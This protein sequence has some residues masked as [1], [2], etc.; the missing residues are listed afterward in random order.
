MKK[1]TLLLSCIKAIFLQPSIAATL[2]E[3]LKRGRTGGLIGIKVALLQIREGKQLTSNKI[4][5]H[6][7][8]ERLKTELKPMILQQ[9]KSMKHKPLIT[10]LIPTYNTPPHFLIKT[11]ESVQNQWYD[12]WELCICDDA[13]KNIKTLTI[14]KNKSKED[15]R[16][17][18]NF[19]SHNRNI[20][21]ATNI[22]L[23]MAQGQYV[24]LLDHDDL[25]QPQ[26]LFRIS[27]TIIKQQPDF[28]YSDEARITKD[29]TDVLDFFLRPQFSLEKL[30]STPYIVHFICFKT[31]FLKKLGGLN[32]TLNISQ[33]YDLILRTAEQTRNIVHIPE[34]L[35]LWRTFSS[36]AGH[37]MQNKVMKTST[38]ILE[39]HLKRC[40]QPGIV[41]QSQFFNFFN[42]RYPL[43]P[44]L[45]VAII[46]PTKNCATLVKQCINS[47]KKTLHS[48]NYEI[49]LVDHASDEKD[50]IEYFA[51][52]KKLHTVLNYH[53]KFNFSAINNFAVAQ[54]SAAALQQPAKKFSHYLFCNNDIEALEDDWL[55]HMLELGQQDD[56]AIV[57]PKLLY[58]DKKQIQH[59]GVG[60]GIFNAAEHYAKF[61]NNYLPTGQINPGPDSILLCN[62]EVS[63]VTAACL[64]IQSHIF[65]QLSG[66]DEQLAIGFGDIDLCLRARAL[67]KRI[68]FT[69]HVS[70]M[71]YESYSRGLQN[72][73]LEDTRLFKQR[74]QS[75][76]EKGDPYYNPNFSKQSYCWDV[77][78]PI[79]ISVAINT[80]S[81]D[82]IFQAQQEL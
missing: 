71:H 79:P 21:G 53:G 30:R 11:I 33:D 65:E 20:S 78:S 58:P 12:N 75:Y 17:K 67:G 38:H 1:L 13:S 15:P 29:D 50:A 66:F 63:A 45:R 57:G 77:E 28:I 14:L 64:L 73:H 26:A 36:S 59:A 4:L 54:L 16:I 80:R 34:I 51:A 55:D 25:L 32:E 3:L 5:W 81:P 41:N 52:L 82:D 49:V 2:W 76:I 18:I 37:K 48:S 42:I 9:I 8:Q 61:M 27:Q 43:K 60:V 56:I 70:L 10:V 40:H 72:G 19:S 7:Y 35:Y 44:D 68:I 47:F 24:L 23:S 22:A 74:W 62:R 69:P 46:I 39:Q 6:Q 31:L